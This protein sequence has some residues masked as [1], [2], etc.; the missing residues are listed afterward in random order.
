V[1]PSTG[2]TGLVIC[3][4]WLLSCRCFTG[5]FSFRSGNYP[6]Y[7]SSCSS[8]TTFSYC[9]GRSGRERLHCQISQ[10]R[11]GETRRPV[12]TEIT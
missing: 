11:P 2:V 10:I 1:A 12:G 6:F 3:T 7:N 4:R 8:M 5:I 9:A